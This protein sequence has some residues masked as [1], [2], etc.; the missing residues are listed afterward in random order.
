MTA[1]PEHGATPDPAG[2]GTN[3]ASAARCER[4]FYDGDCGMCHGAVR[5]ILARDVTGE[6]FRF[7]ALGGETYLRAIDASTRATLP[8]SLV[9]QCMDGRVLVRAAGVLHILARLGGRWRMLAGL[10]RAVPRPLAD[11]LYD[12]IARVRKRL[13]R[14]PTGVCPVIAPELR[15]RFDP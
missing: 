5:F 4:V 3:V 2:V 1:G 8:D 13:F 7:A 10:L 6:A 9:V 15:K 11:L 14:R 12:F